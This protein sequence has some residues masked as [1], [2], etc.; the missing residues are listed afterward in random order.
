[1]S[2]NSMK[3]KIK[4]NQKKKNKLKKRKKNQRIQYKENVWSW[5]KQKSNMQKC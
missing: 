1:M 2:N 4:S 5:K 3:K